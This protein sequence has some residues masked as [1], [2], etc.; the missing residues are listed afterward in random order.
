[1]SFATVLNQLYE[2]SPDVTRGSIVL[3]NAAGRS[4]RRRPA[5]VCAA[6]VLDCAGGFSAGDTV[7]VTFRAV[8]GGQ[9]VI[10]TGVIG[11]DE[12]TLRQQMR[13]TATVVIRETDVKL[14]W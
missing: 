12:I 6:D 8:D 7:Y 1:M 11:C 10:A 2:Q 14:L 13:S 5:T 9:F 3:N 4:L